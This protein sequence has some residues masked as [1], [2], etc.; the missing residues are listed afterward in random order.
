MFRRKDGKLWL[1]ESI[2]PPLLTRFPD[3]T[4]PVDTVLSA[5]MTW[6]P[7]RV[8]LEKHTPSERVCNTS[9]YNPGLD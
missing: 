8:I 5:G 7:E 4:A 6:S 9:E 1:Y 2:F 3:D